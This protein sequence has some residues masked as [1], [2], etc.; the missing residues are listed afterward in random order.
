MN[1]EFEATRK[2]W[3]KEVVKG[4]LI[5][6]DEYVIRFVKRNYSQDKTLLD[7]G[8]GVGR[9]AIALAMC[10]YNL[11]A[12]DYAEEALA[13]VEKKAAGLSVRTVLNKGYEIPLEKKSVDGIIADGSLFYNSKKD[14]I[15]IL[16]NLRECLKDSGKI[17][18][19]WRTKNDS[20]YQRGNLVADGLYKLDSSTKRKDCLYLFCDRESVEDMYNQSKLQI[21]SIDT[22][23]YTENNGKDKC[24]YLQVVA[25]KISD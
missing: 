21:E 18:A 25:S 17:W 12:M 5:W 10:G 6:P 1:S 24:S 7:F 20:L 4:D 19:N 3:K 23:E 15:T 16:S 13:M 14:T 22:L 8:C 9:N 11:I 2:F